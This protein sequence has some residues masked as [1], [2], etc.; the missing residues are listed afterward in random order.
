MR[1]TRLFWP[2]I[3]TFALLS[4]GSL[5][6]NHF[7]Q[8]AQAAPSLQL[9]TSTPFWRFLDTAG[10]GTGTKNA[11]GSTYAT[12]PTN[13]YLQPP[14]GAVYNISRLIVSI[15][16]SAVITPTLYGSVTITNGV[17]LR[18]VSGST[19]ITLTDGISV[20]GN[21]GWR[22]F[23]EVTQTNVSGVTNQL[24]A[25]CDFSPPIRLSGDRSE[26]LEARLADDMSGLDGHY[27]VAEGYRE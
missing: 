24:Q 2:V 15:E 23:C 9:S 5:A 10:D 14:A 1:L 22:R 13:F 17:L 19:V 11:V 7:G 25:V 6:L 20:T 27:F 12:T 16:D 8:T 21:I 4:T 18:R 26:R 3:L